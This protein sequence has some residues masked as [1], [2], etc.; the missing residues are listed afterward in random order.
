[1]RLTPEQRDLSDRLKKVEYLCWELDTRTKQS[2]KVDLSEK[3]RWLK[4]N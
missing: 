1:V 3:F 2:K 4:L